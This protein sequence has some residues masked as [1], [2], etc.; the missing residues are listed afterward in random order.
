MDADDAGSGNRHHIHG[1][2]LDPCALDSL[3]TCSAS[4]MVLPFAM[5]R[6]LV[7]SLPFR[8]VLLLKCLYGMAIGLAVTPFAIAAVLRGP[9]C[10]QGVRCTDRR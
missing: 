8:T 10:S 5:P 1:E 6:L 7:A 9:G 3:A 4:S 2:N